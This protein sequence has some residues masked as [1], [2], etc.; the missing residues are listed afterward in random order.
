MPRVMG[1]VSGRFLACVRDACIYRGAWTLGLRR[2]LGRPGLATGHGQVGGHRRRHSGAGRV[3]LAKKTGAGI[4][5]RACAAMAVGAYLRKY[6]RTRLTSIKILSAGGEDEHHAQCTPNGPDTNGPFR[7]TRISC[8]T[9]SKLRSECGL[10]CQEYG[11]QVDLHGA[12]RCCGNDRDQKQ[13]RTQNALSPKARATMQ[14][15]SR[16]TD[17]QLPLSASGIRWCSTFSL[18]HYLELIY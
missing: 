16:N 17:L 14:T 5:E 11:L 7:D 12:E 8:F 2:R 9:E 15:L 4:L 6:L 3:M 10:G 18:E 1:G 13:P